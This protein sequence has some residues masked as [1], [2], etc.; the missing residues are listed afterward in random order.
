MKEKKAYLLAAVLGLSLAL[1]CPVAADEADPE[2][3]AAMKNPLF[4][5]AMTFLANPAPLPDSVAATEAEMKS[6]TET[7]P[8]TN[9]TFTMV[10]IK[11]GKFTMGSPASEEGRNDDEGPQIE[12]EVKPF[13]ME[14]HETTWLAFEQFALRYLRQNRGVSDTLTERERL[15]DALAAPT[16]LW[17]ISD[18][19]NN[20]GKAG[21][22]AA[23][24]TMYAAQVYCKWL[25]AITGRYYRLPT[26]AEWEYACRAG[27]ATRFS[28][29]D[30]D[31]DLDDYA[32]WFDNTMGDVQQVKQLKPNPWGLY[33][34]HGNIAE[35]VLERYAADTYANRQPGTFAAPVRPALTRVGGQDGINVVRG[36]SADSDESADLR[37]ARRLRYDERWRADDPQF[38][39][40]IWWIVNNPSIGFRV[41]RP[42]EPPKTE[43]EAKLY[44]PDPEIWFEYQK[45]NSRD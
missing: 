4:Q 19:H 28:F 3:E 20:K 13:W 31:G 9:I 14:E 21:Y 26:E 8:G 12:I 6:Y 24:M 42:L 43:E 15:A 2:R 33:D 22:P 27:T 40:S 44:E 38:P 16:N 32:W 30:D 18:S 41:V 45:S 1:A 11:G 39:K 34:M 35:W 29:G 23:G 7:I 17:G 25:T 10:P 37:S 5:S 36:G